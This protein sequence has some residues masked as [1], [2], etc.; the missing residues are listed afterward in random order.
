MTRTSFALSDENA[1]RELIAE[2]H[3]NWEDMEEA[4]SHCPQTEHG[5]NEAEATAAYQQLHPSPVSSPVPSVSGGRR[6]ST[7]AGPE[8]FRI[9]HETR[10]L[11]HVALPSVLIQFSLFFIFPMSASVVGRTQGTVAL[12]GFSLGSLLGNLT[13]LSIME[14]A[15]T[16]A[17]T[18]M[19]R[20]YGNHRY[21]EVGRLAVRAFV[22]VTCLLLPPILPLCWFSRHILTALGQDREASKL[23][24][25]WIQLYFLGVPPN[26]M[27]RVAMRFL[28]AQHLPWPLVYTSVFPALVIHPFLL[29]WLVP[30]LGLP[31]SALAI[32]LTQWCMMLILAGYFWFTRNNPK[33]KPETWPGLSRTLIAEALRPEP[34]YRFFSLSLGGVLS[35]SEWLVT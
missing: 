30:P 9:V 2:S 24:Q 14:G 16:A 34:L 10:Q 23:A 21:D 7:S 27:Y 29:Q 20:A 19:P 4:L 31:G 28:L 26:L 25:E 18:L 17:D 6:S 12:G 32:T 3:S 5:N 15:L 33:W 1:A 35:L 13:C 11:L 22:V 8:P